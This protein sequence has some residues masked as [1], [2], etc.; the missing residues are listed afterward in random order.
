M[1][2]STLR[3]HIRRCSLDNFE[4]CLLNTL[5]RNVTSYG[6]VFALSAYLVYLVNVDNSAFS[7][8]YVKVCRLNKTKK[9]VF[10]VLTHI[11][12]FC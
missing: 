10:N 4:K 7:L 6:T 1:L 11:S 8:F 9:N 5:A 2:S 3:W 12:C